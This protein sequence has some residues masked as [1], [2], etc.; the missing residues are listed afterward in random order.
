MNTAYYST[1]GG[2]D[3]KAFVDHFK[4]QAEGTRTAMLLNSISGAPA[5]R[6]TRAGR[7][8]LILVDTRKDRGAMKNGEITGKI[9]I[10]DPNEAEKRRA[11]GEAVRE[12]MVLDKESKQLKTAHSVV[13]KRKT[14]TSSREGE[15]SSKRRQKSAIYVAK[16]KVKRVK[17]IFDE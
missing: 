7:S 3:Y 12:E 1:E 9:E 5:F 10:V 13:G 11:L 16:S 8:R 17:D 2:G 6:K 14:Q 4:K 15:P